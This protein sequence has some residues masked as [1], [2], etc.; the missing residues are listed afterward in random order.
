MRYWDGAAWT[1]HI[2]PPPPRSG[3]DLLVILGYIFAAVF[4]IAGIVLGG[5]VLARNDRTRRSG[6]WII[7][8]SVV[9][10]CFETALS[11]YAYA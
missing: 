7:G 2:A 8:I 6:Y 4:P 10:F 1:E 11:I 3:P 5:Y 9:M